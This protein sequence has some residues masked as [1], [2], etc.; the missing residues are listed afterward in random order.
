MRQVVVVGGGLAG[1]TAALECA[2]AGAAVTLL[3]ARPRLGGATFSVEKEGLWLDNGQ[4]VFL[5]CC[6]AYVALHP[7]ARR[8]ERRRAPAAAARSRS[9]APGGEDGMAAPERPAAA[10]PSRRVAASLRSPAARDRVRLGPAVLALRRLRLGIRRSTSR[11]FGAW[12]D[13]ARPVRR[14]RRGALGPDHAAHGQPARAR[15]V[16]RAGDQGVPDRSARSRRRLGRRLCARPAAAAARRTRPRRALAA[17]GVDAASRRR[18]SPR[19]SRRTQ[20]CAVSWAGGTLEA[21]AVILAVPHEEAVELLPAGALPARRRS[22]AGSARRRSS[23]CTSST[24][25]RSPSC[26]VRRR[27]R[28]AGAVGLRPDELRRAADGQ[29]LAVSLSGADAYISRSVEEL[30]AEFVPALA[31]LFPAARDGRG[32]VVLRHPRAARDVQRRAR[33]RGAPAGPVTGV[34][35]SLPRRRLDRHRLA[36][37]DGGR[38]PE[39]SGGRPGGRSVPTA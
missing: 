29:C 20:A 6:T 19:C 2:D 27:C 10:A 21:D 30:R 23:T 34:P 36:G 31:A 14:R 1:I 9:L 17:A 16:A 4:H 3:E 13:G 24:T 37:D 5:R 7:R 38:G 32:D 15:R 25:A 22:G 26:A 11:R 33:H 18:A 39:R 28:H 8:R 12:L 35:G